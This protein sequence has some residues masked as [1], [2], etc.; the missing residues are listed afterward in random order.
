V[1]PFVALVRSVILAS[2]L[3]VSFT[4]SNALSFVLGP[5]VVFFAP[6]SARLDDED[7]ALLDRA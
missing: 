4:P 1:R 3:V 7:K 5:Y 6:G 2:A